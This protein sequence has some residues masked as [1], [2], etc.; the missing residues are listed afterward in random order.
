M[1]INMEQDEAGLKC[2]DAL[3]LIEEAIDIIDNI[4]KF[5]SRIQPNTPVSPGSVYQIYLN[6]VTLREKVV[7]ARM[8]IVDKCI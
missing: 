7:E 6:L 2:S 3:N 4:E 8:I 5:I 1:L